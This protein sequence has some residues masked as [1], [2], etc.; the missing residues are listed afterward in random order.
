MAYKQSIIDVKM[1][2]LFLI[3]KFMKSVEK[4]VKKKLIERSIITGKMSFTVLYAYSCQEGCEM[5]DLMLCCIGRTELKM[6][7]VLRWAEIFEFFKKHGIYQ[8]SLEW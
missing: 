5:E 6:F 4:N 1:S 8:E 3:E 7:G 2:I